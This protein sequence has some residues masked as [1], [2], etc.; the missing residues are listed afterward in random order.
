MMA[1]LKR[2]RAV[3]VEAPEGE[4][5][6]LEIFR[7]GEGSIYVFDL[8]PAWASRLLA[9]RHPNQ[10]KI[11]KTHASIIG[12]AAV[13]G[14]FMWLGEAI[15]IDRDGRLIN[16]QHRCLGVAQADVTI[17]NQILVMALSD[18]A[19]LHLDATRK[20]RSLTDLQAMSGDRRTPTSV[21]A[22][23]L[24]EASGFTT[25]SVR[26]MSRPE[27]IQMIRA[28]PY[29]AELSALHA[30]SIAA[31]V[32]YTRGVLAV[33]A[34]ALRLD[35][36]QAMLFFGAIAD[37][38]A[39]SV[40]GG[41]AELFLRWYLRSRVSLGLATSRARLDALEVAYKATA[42]WNAWREGRTLKKLQSG[43]K[44]TPPAPR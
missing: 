36:D 6:L 26:T 41:Q 32:K 20:T 12:R 9:N 11:S 39:P 25:Q 28:Y 37:N 34:A 42:A 30:R 24:F 43:R 14:E 3:P 5:E 29:T 23:I 17:K 2:V 8:S 21:N 13:N 1:K 31:G 40:P 22:G 35:Y 7:C 27:R 15:H 44:G 18:N 38:N 19:L 4:D 33:A 10:R 16:G